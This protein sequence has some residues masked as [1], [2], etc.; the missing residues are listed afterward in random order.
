MEELL[1]LKTKNVI[2]DL[3]EIEKLEIAISIEK[4]DKISLIKLKKKGLNIDLSIAIDFT[5][6][7]G[8]PTALILYII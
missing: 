3:P 8:Y 5:S 6:S 4:F 2:I 7:N 1:N